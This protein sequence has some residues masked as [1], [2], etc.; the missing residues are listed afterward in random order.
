[1][2]PTSSVD[3]SFSTTG[4][5]GTNVQGPHPADDSEGHDFETR[6]REPLGGISRV[7]DRD[8]DERGSLDKCLSAHPNGDRHVTRKDQTSRVVS[9]DNTR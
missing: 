5:D 9:A 4:N 7:K 3:M 8:Y 1:M 6:Y 2:I